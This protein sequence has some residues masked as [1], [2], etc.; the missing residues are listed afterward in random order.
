MP[1]TWDATDASEY[2]TDTMMEQFGNV[3][4]YN[5][6]SG[7]AP[8]ASGAN[9]NV[10]VAS[11]SITHNG[12]VVTVAGGSVALV[13]D[14]TN[15]RFS[16]VALDSTGAPVLVSGTAAADPVPPELGDY[17]EVMLCKVNAGQTVASSG[18]NWD[19][20]LFAPT[21]GSASVAQLS[22]SATNNSTTLADVS[23]L[24]LAVAANSTYTFK[25][26]GGYTSSSSGDYKFAFTVP[27]AATIRAEVLYVDTSGSLTLGSLTSS[28]GTLSGDG[29]T[30]PRLVVVWGSVVTGANAGTL[31]FQHALNTAAGTATTLL[32]SRLELY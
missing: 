9:M 30:D 17:V 13:A 10:T 20:R 31:Q 16:W 19:R 7:C 4:K 8:T 26:H 27:A 11:G 29:S 1:R 6:V 14:G 32:K 24:G 5:V 25:Y 23:E 3:A 21:V 12:S 2:V 22:T 15:P 28:G 18:T